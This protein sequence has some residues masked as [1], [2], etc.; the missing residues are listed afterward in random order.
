MIEQVQQWLDAH[1]WAAAF[2][3]SVVAFV[4]LP[5]RNW[6]NIRRL[7]AQR[8]GDR[9]KLEEIHRDVREV[10]AKLFQHVD[11]PKQPDHGDPSHADFR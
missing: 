3:G 11:R 10:R 7:Q 9:A 2:A 8:D 1:P 6:S 5:V 4:A